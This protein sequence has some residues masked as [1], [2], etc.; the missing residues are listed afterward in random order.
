M[1]I[2]EIFEKVKKNSVLSI[3]KKTLFSAGLENGIHPII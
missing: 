1:F 2:P 3:G